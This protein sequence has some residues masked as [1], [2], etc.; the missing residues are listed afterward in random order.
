MEEFARIIITLFLLF[1]GAQ[2]PAGAPPVDV[3]QEAAE[4]FRSPTIIDSVDAQILESFPA[5]I[6]LAVT[7]SQPDGCDYPVRVE[8]HRDGSTITVEIFREMPLAVMCPMMLLPYEDTI[9]LEGTFESG[10]YT[11]IVNDYTLEVTV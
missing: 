1:A 11:I 4:T 10:T 7:G 3:P 5:Q 9:P 2:L 6:H 8:Q